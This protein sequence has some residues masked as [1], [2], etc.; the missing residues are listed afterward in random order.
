MLEEPSLNIWGI[1]PEGSSAALFVVNKLIVLSVDYKS[2][3][4]Y[5]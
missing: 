2:V 4:S 1:K 5:R 3:I